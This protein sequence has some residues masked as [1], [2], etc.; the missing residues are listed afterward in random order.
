MPERGRVGWVVGIIGVCLAAI[1]IVVSALAY[2]QDR[3]GR[4]QATRPDLAVVQFEPTVKSELKA[5]EISPVDDK[6]TPL[7]DGWRGPAV[8]ISVLNSGEEPGLLTQIEV[9]VRKVW[10]MSGCWGAGGSRVTAHYDVPLPDELFRFENALP[11]RM[12]CARM[13]ISRWPART[14]TRLPWPSA[15][16]RRSRERGRACTRW[17]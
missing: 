13:R 17:T 10:L 2:W 5:E 12:L 9:T 15:R 1:A 16:R 8:T 11:C 7:Q 14:L 3:A 6:A 4:I